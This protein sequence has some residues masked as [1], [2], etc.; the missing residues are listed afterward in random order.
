[1]DPPA[2]DSR[3]FIQAISKPRAKKLAQHS[4][5]NSCDFMAYISHGLKPD[6]LREQFPIWFCEHGYRI[7]KMS[8]DTAEVLEAGEDEK[9][10]AAVGSRQRQWAVGNDYACRIRI[11][12]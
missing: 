7:V 3:S 9:D 10:K 11:H 4:L 12:I 6:T 8:P 1:L 2:Q 5:R